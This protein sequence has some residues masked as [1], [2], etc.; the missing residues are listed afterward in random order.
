ME[1]IN[2]LPKSRVSEISKR[3][4]VFNESV[5]GP[6]EQVAQKSELEAV[7]AREKQRGQSA[8][9]GRGSQRNKSSEKAVQQQ[10]AAPEEGHAN[11]E[12]FGP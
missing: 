10:A 4:E 5:G 3:Y 1:I 6:E 7:S 12:E 8:R 9:S 2:S 11:T